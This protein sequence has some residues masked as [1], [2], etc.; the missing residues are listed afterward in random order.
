MSTY[1]GEPAKPL[2]TEMILGHPI[3]L[4]PFEQMLVAR[5]IA[6]KVM[7]G[8]HSAPRSRAISIADYD[9]LR[10][11]LEPPD[12]WLIWLGIGGGRRWTAAYYHQSL[13]IASDATQPSQSSSPRNAQFT[14]MGLGKLIVHA[15]TTPI[16]IVHPT[17]LARHGLISIWPKRDPAIHWPQVDVGLTDPQVDEL[18]SALDRALLR[19]GLI[20]LPGNRSPAGG[21]LS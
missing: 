4:T 7:V 5:W 11:H 3:T 12:H 14:T 1:F 2:L 13:T 16:Q 17:A 6:L 9:H 21:R 18:T 19:S 15:V 20:I 8:E 10:L